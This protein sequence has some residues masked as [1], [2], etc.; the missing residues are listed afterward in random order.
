MLI[1]LTFIKDP[2]HCWLVSFRV[3]RAPAAV[4]TEGRSAVILGSINKTVLFCLSYCSCSLKFDS[5]E[6][7]NADGEV[8]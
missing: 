7:N 8:I 2:P 3:S 5:R 6:H 1:T 4:T